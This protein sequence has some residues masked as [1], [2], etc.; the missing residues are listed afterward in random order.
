MEVKGLKSVG[1]IHVKVLHKFKQL[2]I[3]VNKAKCQ[4][5]VNELEYL[6][7][8]IS[9]EGYIPLQNHKD[10]ITQCT[11]P[12]NVSQLR[13]FTGMVNYF[14]KNIPHLATDAHKLLHESAK[15]D[16]TFEHQQQFEK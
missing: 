14:Q 7:H 3:K 11:R 6:G 13:S 1:V 2:N 12:E 9:A 4:F 8:A 5:F 15:W 16:W 10:T